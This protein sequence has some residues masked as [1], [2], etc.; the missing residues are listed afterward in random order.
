MLEAVLTSAFDADMDLIA[1]Y[2][3]KY[4]IFE[5][6]RPAPNP[7]AATALLE[8]YHEL[9]ER[10]PI[11]RFLVADEYGRKLYHAGDIENASQW[12]DMVADTEL[13]PN[14][15]ERPEY[16]RVRSYATAAH[17]PRA[18][19]VQILDAV[20]VI[21]TNQF[22]TDLER[23]KL[24]G[25][26]AVAAFLV[27]ELNEAIDLMEAGY[28]LLLKS[29]RNT[30][31]FQAM[32][33]RYG[34]ALQYYVQLRD[35]GK[36]PEKA[37][38]GSYSVPSRGY[39][40]LDNQLLL[41]D[42]FYFEERRFIVSFLLQGAY[43]QRG[44]LPLSKKWALMA[45]QIALGIN[46]PQYLV[47]LQKNLGYLVDD[48][49]PDHLFSVF[50]YLN[51]F[52]PLTTRTREEQLSAGEVLKRDQMARNLREHDVIFYEYVL[53]PVLYKLML[54]IIERRLQDAELPAALQSLFESPNL[55]VNDPV[56]LAFVRGLLEKIWINRI[57]LASM[58]ELVDIYEGGYKDEVKFI[59]QLAYS[60]YGS[61]YEAADLQLATIR[62][63]EFIFTAMNSGA[64]GF[65]I[66]PFY[67][68][69]WEQ[70]FRAFPSEFGDQVFWL[71]K[72]MP[73][74]EKAPINKKLNRLFQA[75]VFHLKLS[76]DVSMDDW[77][78]S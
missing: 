31:D 58:Y 17:D 6:Y 43:E 45:I 40:Y 28:D 50:N 62:R 51:R 10:H 11:Y 76:T 37:L 59:G 78:D 69:F 25:E 13:P 57:D 46:D 20:T 23:V 65:Y 48:G 14:Y 54:D 70:R 68:K 47:V 55:K 21:N 49:D 71:E 52:I 39:Y 15:S 63:Q 30:E 3:L 53:V 74:V 73:R 1:A 27:G 77:L 8:R 9:T 41:A 66:V 4:M 7:A 12:L 35:T 33:I 32:V 64:Y 34:S 5:Y 19:Y 2:A 26:A 36:A 67:L 56:T 75:L 42:G 44:N 16:Q 60:L 22:N 29:Y 24:Y 38:G 18:A 61:N 72:S